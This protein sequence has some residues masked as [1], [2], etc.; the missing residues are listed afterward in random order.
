MIDL[1][2]RS[3]EKDIIAHYADGLGYEGGLKVH[4]ELLDEMY[5]PALFMDVNISIAR[6]AFLNRL[7]VAVEKRLGLNK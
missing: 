4:L 5:D 3:F 1:L 2:Y 7:H 6:T